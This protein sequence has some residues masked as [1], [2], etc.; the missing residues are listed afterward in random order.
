LRPEVLLLAHG[1][2]IFDGGSAALERF[3]REGASAEF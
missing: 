1:E 3:S 2:P